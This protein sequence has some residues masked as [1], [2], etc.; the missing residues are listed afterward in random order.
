[1]KKNLYN[2]PNKQ[3]KEIAIL[4]AIRECGPISRTKIAKIFKLSA[5][6]VTKWEESPNNPVGPAFEMAGGTRFNGCYYLTGQGEGSHFPRS[7]KLETHASMTSS[8]IAGIS[9]FVLL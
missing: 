2:Q 6:T 5:V 4:N 3:S 9:S 7:R 1:M 8:G